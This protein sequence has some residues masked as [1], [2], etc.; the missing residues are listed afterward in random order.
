M[1]NKALVVGLGISGESA[2]KFLANNGWEISEYD[3]KNKKTYSSLNQTYSLAVVSPGI[4]E[5]GDVMKFI[6]ENNIPCF[7]EVELGLNKMDTKNIIGITGTN[8]KT[9]CTTL[10]NHI[11][12]FAGKKSVACGNNKIPATSVCQSLSKNDYCVVELSSFMLQKAKNVH[13]KV[14]CFL[15]FAP[16]HLDFHSNLEEYFNSKK[17]IFDFQNKNDYAIINAD[18]EKVLEIKTL[19]QAF[20][21]STK[22][23]VKGVY[24]EKDFLWFFD[25]EK[26]QKLFS[27]NKIQLLG[28]FNLSN[29]CACTLMAILLKVPKTKIA[30]AVEV[31]K[32]LK[33]RLNLV[34]NKNFKVIND[35]KATNVASTLASL[36]CFDKTILIAGGSDKGEKFDELFKQ[37]KISCKL[38]VLTGKTRKKM[39]YYAIKND[40][41]NYV[42]KTSFKGAIN[43]ALRS[44]KEGD[45]VLFSPSCASFD[46]FKNFEKRGEKF[47]EIVRA[48]LEKTKG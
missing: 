35:S 16:D 33:H 47:E 31:F 1:K 24:V 14:A 48:Y 3:E 39:K 32:P 38:V 7:C 37:A 13:F 6:R 28:E 8:G 46:H 9:T 17:R 25:G 15:N 36:K 22:K 11:L 45:V 4:K 29:V 30:K 27:K 44:A 19:G 43:F 20:F 5:S 34:Y 18:D 2:K 23:Q 21:Y 41:S 26:K 42:L 12:N 40:F 10:L